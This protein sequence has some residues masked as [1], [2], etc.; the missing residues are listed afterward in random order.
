MQTL[1][2]SILIL[3]SISLITV[4]G[5]AVYEHLAIVPLW[6]SA[7]PASLAMFQGEYA[8]TP[9]RFWALIHPVT[10]ILLILA[11]ILN[12]RTPRRWFIALGIAGYALALVATAFFFVP[13]LMTL[14]GTTYSA[15]VDPEL[16]A[17]ARTWETG[18]LMRLGL[19]FVSAFILLF[20]LSKPASK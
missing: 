20:G 17:R 16:T 19:L 2:T 1:R 15:T 18:S 14:T 13:E 10:L 5:G 12:W 7:V 11:L 6:A 4:I 8:I 3:A 9:I